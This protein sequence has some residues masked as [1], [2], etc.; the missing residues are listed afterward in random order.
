VGRVSDVPWQHVM[1]N[2][3][4]KNP[5]YFDLSTDMQTVIYVAGAIECPGQVEVVGE[6]I[7]VSTQAK[8]PSKSGGERHSELHLDVS[9]FRCLP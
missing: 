4:G 7:E 8:R 9:S 5:E 6:V 2:V 1:G 3:P